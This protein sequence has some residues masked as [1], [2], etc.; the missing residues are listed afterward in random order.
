MKASKGHILQGYFYWYGHRDN[1]RIIVFDHGMGS[2]HRG[3]MREIETLAR[4][5][6]LVFSYDHTGCDES[7][8]ETTGGFL[9]SLADLDDIL[10]AFEA[11]ET[12]QGSTFSV[13]GHSW[14]A[15]ATLNIPSLHPAVTHLV[16]MSGFLSLEAIIK[17]FAG[18]LAAVRPLIRAAEGK[19]NP[20]FLKTSAVDSLQNFKGR[21]MVIHSSD[22][23]TVTL[24]AHYGVLEKAFGEREGFVFLKEK[25][26]AHNP[27]YTLDAALE[28]ARFFRSYH[29]ARRKGVLSTEE[30]KRDFLKGYDFYRITEQDASVWEK[31]FAFLEG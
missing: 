26:K 20:R 1:S 31:I 5:G 9:Q 14:G 28:K 8:G 19:D 3:Y 30:G 27:N 23:K 25:G 6:Y 18:P 2:G 22:D 10:T 15:F 7:G 12:Y 16:A 29:R 21:V 11:D 13:M 17:R 24:K 4:R